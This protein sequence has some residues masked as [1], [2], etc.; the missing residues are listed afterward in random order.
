MVPS[1]RGYKEVYRVSLPA[2]LRL[3]GL[4]LGCGLQG[5]VGFRWEIVEIRVPVWV[6]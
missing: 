5:L 6:P 2:L 3:Q 4:G 1:S